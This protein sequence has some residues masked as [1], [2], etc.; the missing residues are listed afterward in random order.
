MNGGAIIGNS[1]SSSGAQSG[2]G[3]FVGQGGTFTMNVGTISKN[4][5]GIGG[6]GI[7]LS[8]KATITMSEGCSI[9]DNTAGGYG[10]GIS[11]SAWNNEN[12]VSL[13]MTGGTISNNK[14]DG[15]GGGVCFGTGTFN[16]TG[17]S[18]TDNT[19][20]SGGGV[21]RWQNIQ[22]QCYGWQRRWRVCWGTFVNEH[23]RWGSIWKQCSG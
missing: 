2:G 22:Q 16:V 7:C 11:A 12:P 23:N 9:I 5:A 20:Q 3:V 17:G 19:A 15:D 13:T 1:A 10:G 21:I 18:I 8:R 14:T 4:I 6:G